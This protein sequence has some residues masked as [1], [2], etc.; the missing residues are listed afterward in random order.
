MTDPTDKDPYDD[1]FAEDYDPTA[2]F[3][4][5]ARSQIREKLDELRS[6]RAR[7]QASSSDA[8]GLIARSAEKATGVYES[9]LLQLWE[10]ARRCVDLVAST[11]PAS[12]EH[13]R[14]VHEAI[15]L[16]HEAIPVHDEALRIAAHLG[17]LDP[18]LPS[19]SPQVI[20]KLE[21]PRSASS[22]IQHD[23]RTWLD[24]HVPQRNGAMV[25]L[26]TTPGVG[27]THQMLRLASELQLREKRRVIFAARTKAMIDSPEAELMKRAL[28]TSPVARNYTLPIYGRDESNCY[29][30]DTVKI[31]QEHGYFP[32][33]SVCVNCEHHPRNAHHVG[34]PV[35]GYYQVRIRAANMS[36]GVRA[37]RMQH[38]PLILTTHAALV[39]ATASDGGMYGECW[40]SDVIFFDEDPTDALESDTVLAEPQM[41]F[42]SARRDHV[43]TTE[44]ASVLREAVKLASTQRSQSMSTGFCAAGSKE[45]GSHPIHSH[46]DSVYA[47]GDLWDLLEF[48]HRSGGSK[49]SLSALLRNVIESGS[50]HVAAGDLSGVADVS[51][52]HARDIPPRTLLTIATA[53]LREHRHR[54]DVGRL[55][56]KKMTGEVASRSKI[57]QLA[58]VR[59]LAYQVRLECLPAS[60][61]KKRYRDEWRFVFRE[62]RT[63]ANSMSTLVVGDAYAQREHYGYLFNRKP[64]V[65][66]AVSYLHPDA[67]QIRVLHDASIS[68]LT[69]G[70]LGDVLA[71]TEAFLRDSVKPGDR[72]LVYGHNELRP[73]VEKFLAALAER[74]GLAA[75]AYEHWWGGRGKDIYGG[76]EHVVTISDPVLSIGG[77]KH[78]VNARAFRDSERARDD[79]EKLAHANRIGLASAKHGLIQALRS[80]HPRLVQEHERSNVAELTQAIHRVRPVHNPARIYTIGQMERSPDLLAQTTTFVP[81]DERFEAVS[82]AR[83][84]SKKP[85]AGSK[86]IAIEGALSAFT[87]RHEVL[88]AIRSVVDWFGVWHPHFS[89]ALVT[90]ANAEARVRGLAPQACSPDGSVAHVCDSKSQVTPGVSVVAD[91]FQCRE[92]Q[93]W[94]NWISIRPRLQSEHFGTQSGPFSVM[95]RNPS[96]FLCQPPV[97]H[98]A[99][100]SSTATGSPQNQVFCSGLGMLPCFDAAAGTRAST[101]VAPSWG[102]RIGPDGSPSV[103]PD[104]RSLVDRVWDPPTWWEA[105][106][107]IEN[108]PKAIREIS[109]AD[110]EGLGLKPFTPSQQPAWM[111]GR[112]G[113]KPTAWFDPS[114]TNGSV[115]VADRLLFRILNSQYGYPH[116]DGHL[117]RP[118]FVP[119]RPE[120]LKGV[121]F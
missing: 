63:F 6:L 121:P 60:I 106:S 10:D 16:L 45:R 102:V 109:S 30:A 47:S 77:L 4:F 44:F 83:R 92:L 62:A 35:C 36:K 81:E 86:T 105:L 54:E 100:P 93:P 12:R 3:A 75:W 22:R 112:P 66:E 61:D 33:Q 51:E 26:H 43:D 40:G 39:S 80:S 46:Y 111:A 37:G 64:D 97:A 90:A 72:V 8:T 78:V 52:I 101:V 87:T 118:N 82:A 49:L 115:T 104:G 69:R 17:A 120:P 50:F 103:A 113:R 74:Y 110:L 68:Q 99:H 11:D 28:A 20:A 114:L 88:M 14:A 2:A 55:I 18:Q 38:Y 34:L 19:I 21:D 79:D 27:K 91:G 31:A 117:E 89:H 70:Y 73:R 119:T 23:L 84:K 48:V 71:A 41:Q 116:R 85:R 108:L 32:G 65:I 67:V 25:I 7:K 15:R 29:Q 57:E 96:I 58:D 56:L 42:Q 98:V 53:L 107:R 24:E 76:W 9:Q 13:D 5:Q 95:S 1:P 94:S 59:D